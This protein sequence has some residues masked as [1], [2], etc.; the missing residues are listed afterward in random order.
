MDSFERARRREQPLD[1]ETLERFARQ[2]LARAA[3]S[4]FVGT[5]EPRRV[6]LAGDT[7]GNAGWLATLTK[8]AARH[9]C[10]GIVQLGDFG[11]W[12]HVPSGE[13]FL[14][15]VERSLERQGIWLLVSPGNHDNHA[16]LARHPQGPAGLITL[17]DRIAVA[18]FGSRWR[19]RCVRFGALGG[20][21]SVD[22]APAPLGLW[23]GRTPGWDWWP[24]LEEPNEADA[25][26]LGEAPLDIL[27][28]HDAPIDADLGDK[29][30]LAPEAEWR[31][32][33]TRRLI[34][35]VV[36]RLRPSLVVHGHWHRRNSDVIGRL[37]P[38]LSEAAG[39]AVW[40]ET[41][42]E[43]LAHD[44]LASVYSWAVLCLDG[45][46]MWRFV[47]GNRAGVDLERP[48]EPPCG[49]IATDATDASGV[50]AFV[51]P[52]SGAAGAT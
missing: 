33:Q 38:V 29:A 30:P 17:R 13:K 9:H 24:G 31:A 7:H 2:A 36:G 41:R 48:S 39:R 35:D 5:G 47:P 23:P 27:I 12:S 18:P 21:F 22:W 14:D 44:K 3:G 19:W 51:E 46:G 20:A 45:E 11:Y 37:D 8:L 4:R 25:A 49:A 40:A 10:E 42:I 16:L 26:R 6:L 50:G 43:G 28:T 34:S 32:R 15:E 52:T 1:A